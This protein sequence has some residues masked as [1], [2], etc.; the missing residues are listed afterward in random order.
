LD[1]HGVVL[2]A[3]NRTD[4]RTCVRANAILARHASS[5][6]PRYFG[7]RNFLRQIQ[8][9][10]AEGLHRRCLSFAAANQGEIGLGQRRQTV[11]AVDDAHAR[12]NVFLRQYRN[13]QA[14]Q[15]RRGRVLLVCLAALMFGLEISS[16]PVILPT[17]ENRCTAI[18]ATCNGS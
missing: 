5:S 2:Q 15:D 18:S 12:L 6:R 14:R 16:V 3:E 7:R 17:L 1:L 8:N 11:G 10:L 9:Q 4:G 13:R